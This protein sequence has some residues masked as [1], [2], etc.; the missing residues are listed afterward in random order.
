VSTKR[1]KTPPDAGKPAGNGGGGSRRRG[2]VLREAILEAVLEL[3]GTAGY[4]GL[5]MEGVAVAAGTGKAALYRRWASREDLVADALRYALPSPADLAP[6]D[7]VR[8]DVL[9]LLRCVRE[10]FATTHGAAAFQAVKGSDGAGAGMLQPVV[11]ERVVEPFERAMLEALRR[12]VERG[13]VR[14]QAVTLEVARVGLAMLIHHALTD[15]S[16]ITDEHLVTIADDVVLPI[17]RP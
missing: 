1:R 11:Q 15:G 3:L 17:V 13:Q 2:S 12:G 4:A 8:S 16:E 14:P 7:S 5:T 6:Q 10:A 9:A